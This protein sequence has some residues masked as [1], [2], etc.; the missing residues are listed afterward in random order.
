MYPFERYMK[1]LKRYVRNYYRPEDCIIESYVAKEIVEFCTE[2]LHD[3]NL[4]GT[5]ADRNIT[6]K[7]GRGDVR[8][9]LLI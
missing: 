7:F 8:P 9:K 4:I 6:D 3:V 1:V 5:H 2:Y